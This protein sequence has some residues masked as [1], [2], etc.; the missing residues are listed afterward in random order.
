MFAVLA[1]IALVSPGA[2]PPPGVA[3][4]LKSILAVGR[5]GAGN[6]AAAA[7]WRQV[8]AA[9]PAALVPTLTAFDTATP[10]AANWLR[11]A[12]DALAA[13]PGRSRDAA[14]LLAFV[15]D[16][17]RHPAARRIAFELA[18]DTDPDAAAAVLETLIND[19]SIELRRDAIQAR[20]SGADTPALRELFAAARDADQC[21][22]LAKKLKAAGDKPDLTQHY[23]FVTEWKVMG[24]FPVPAPAG[25]SEKLPPETAPYDPG[26]TAAGR[27][28]VKLSWRTVQSDKVDGEID[29]NA[30]LGKTPSVVAYL[31]AVI[32]APADTPAEVRLSTKN[33]IKVFLNGEVV[34][35]REA[36][37]QG[38][39]RDQYAGKMALKKGRNVVMLKVCQN[40]Q[41]QPWAKDWSASARLCDETGGKLPIAQLPP[42]DSAV[43]TPHP[44]GRLK[45]A[46][47]PTAPEKK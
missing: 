23:G 32:E 43:S 45:P 19:R 26:M 5:E 13:A 15:K 34:L 9:G 16:Q 10:T 28:G 42:S 6:E 14:P 33:A 20:M 44:L 4:G 22:E 35:A 18:K 12:V 38:Q 25:Y 27:D 47:A 31:A 29:L 3:G 8:V 39:S 24:P 17:A 1:A 41:P 21:E 40:D 11:A 36:Y 7:G 30:L 2:E 46:P 37:H